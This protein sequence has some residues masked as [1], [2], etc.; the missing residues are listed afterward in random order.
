MPA[1]AAEKARAL[2]KTSLSEGQL[3]SY[4]TTGSFPVHGSQGGFFRVRPRNEWT[5]HEMDEAGEVCA[6][7]CV[8]LTPLGAYPVADQMLA[9]KLMIETDEGWFRDIANRIP[10]A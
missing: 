8:V 1:G 4:V 2:L 3:H 9:M 7:W 10:R 6:R 5:V